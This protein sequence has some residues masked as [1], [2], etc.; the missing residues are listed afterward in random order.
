[1]ETPQYLC[2]ACST[3][4]LFSGEK[5]CFVSYLTPIYAHFF[6]SFCCVPLKSLA[7]FVH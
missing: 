7:E 5:C 2:T 6:L 1:M 4:R 3:A